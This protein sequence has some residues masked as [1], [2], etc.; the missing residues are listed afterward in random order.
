[1]SRGCDVFPANVV[2]TT[3]QRSLELEE[4]SIIYD[5][6]DEFLDEVPYLPPIGEVVF[7]IDLVLDITSIFKETYCMALL[8][9][10]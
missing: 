1:M 7:A 10:R 3:K 5:L 2:A 8:E 4:I 9:F 6:A